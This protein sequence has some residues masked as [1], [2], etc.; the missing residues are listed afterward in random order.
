[1]KGIHENK[2]KQSRYGDTVAKLPARYLISSKS[3]GGKT[4]LI[5]SLITDFYKGCF[6]KVY[7]MSRTVHLDP[8]WGKI[9]EWCEEHCS[10]DDGE[11]FAFD[12]LR[13]DVLER[14]FEE[15]KAVINQ[16]KRAK[17]PLLSQVA[18]VLDDMSG[19]AA[20]LRRDD[21]AV[22]KLYYAGRHYGCTVISSI[23]ALSTLNGLA[24]KSASCLCIFRIA[25][26]SEM[27]FVEDQYAALVGGVDVFRE[28][29]NLAIAEQYSFLVI[30]PN[31]PLNRMF[32]I[33]FEQRILLEPP[34]P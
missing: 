9:K 28:M 8:V 4:T 6:T 5:G 26:G 25:A 21:N 13:L 10:Y 12:G 3:A 14:I 24:R 30:M 18:V 15:R 2:F 20:L 7:I 34:S 33:R 1:M 23:H 11:E 16:E 22:N 29:Y 27:Q 31:E 32:M 19:S 17:K